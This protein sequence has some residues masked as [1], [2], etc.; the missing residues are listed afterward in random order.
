MKDE[1]EWVLTTKVY[2][3]LL[4]VI[5]VQFSDKSSARYSCV[6]SFSVDDNRWHFIFA[7]F[8]TFYEIRR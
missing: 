1:L 6:R 7:D 4:Y 2:A 5:A 8:S 3:F